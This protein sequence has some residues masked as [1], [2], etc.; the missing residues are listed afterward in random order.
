MTT[1]KKCIFKN[2][3]IKYSLPYPPMESNAVHYRILDWEC[4]HLGPSRFAFMVDHGL[5]KF[6]HP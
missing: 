1:L 3:N 6:S 2:L 5:E 4:R